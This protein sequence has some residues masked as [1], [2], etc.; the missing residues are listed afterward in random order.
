MMEIS[1][2]VSASHRWPYNLNIFTCKYTHGA[3]S[4][5]LYS[6]ILL[7]FVL[8]INVP[9]TSKTREIMNVKNQ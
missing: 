4:Y 9:L 7:R 6:A 1:N 8:K 2:I 3:S 5:I